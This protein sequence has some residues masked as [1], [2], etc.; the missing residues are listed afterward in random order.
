MSAKKDL[1]AFGIGVSAGAALAILYAPQSG[2]YTRRQLR[3]GVEDAEHYLG[4][5][6]D[7]LK[8]QAERLSNEAH[9]AV[10]RTRQEVETAV[11]RAGDLVVSALKSAQSLV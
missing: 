1:L 6:S 7:Y 3:R 8:G 2:E 4:S 10:N 5:A 9:A 11:D